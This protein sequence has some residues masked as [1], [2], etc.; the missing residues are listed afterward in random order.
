MLLVDFETDLLVIFDVNVKA[1]AHSLAVE[2]GTE[3]AGDLEGS[4]SDDVRTL[5]GEDS[6]DGGQNPELVDGGLMGRETQRLHCVL[7]HWTRA[8]YLVECTLQRNSLGS[9]RRPSEDL[10]WES[11]LRQKCWGVV[12][13]LRNNCQCPL[14]APLI[15]LCAEE[16]HTASA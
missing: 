13:A 4:Y 14:L 7:A 5:A 8:G 11:R 10:H 9:V 3:I 15:L 12:I 16:A 6:S 2:A 1:A